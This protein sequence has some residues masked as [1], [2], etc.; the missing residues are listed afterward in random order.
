VV[1]GTG[2]SATY[3]G[4]WPTATRSG[5]LGWSLPAGSA[6]YWETLLLTPLFPLF[7]T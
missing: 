4:L 5:L 3:S 1:V 2:L 6:L 7:T